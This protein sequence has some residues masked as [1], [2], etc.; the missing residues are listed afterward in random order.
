MLEPEQHPGSRR[1]HRAR[2]RL[3]P[4]EPRRLVADR[5]D[6]VDPAAALEEPRAAACRSCSRTRAP[7][8]TCS[9]DG[10]ELSPAVPRQPPASRRS[11]RRPGCC[12]ARGPSYIPPRVFALTL[13]D[14]LDPMPDDSGDAAADEALAR[15]RGQGA[16]RSRGRREGQGDGARPR[17]RRAGEARGAAVTN[18]VLQEVADGRADE[19]RRRARGHPAR[20]RDVV[21]LGDQPR[22]RLVQAPRPRS[23]SS[24]SRSSPRWR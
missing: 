6:V 13:L 1:R 17:R 7:P 8:P 9:H 5:G 15:R 14:T 23:W 24:C 3:L 22:Q 10:E 20:A 2:V 12:R 19:G 21:R 18:P 4:A 11:G 16:H